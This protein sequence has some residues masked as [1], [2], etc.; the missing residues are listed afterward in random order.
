MCRIRIRA[1]STAPLI[2]A[3]GEDVERF[4]LRVSNVNANCSFGYFRDP[5]PEAFFEPSLISPNAAWR[6]DRVRMIGKCLELAKA[7]GAGNISIT[8]GRLLGGVPPKRAEELLADGWFGCW[9][10]R[11]GPG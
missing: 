7:V 5:P 6:E 10:W 11:I 2:Y 9:I 3:D 4:G 8:S 1:G